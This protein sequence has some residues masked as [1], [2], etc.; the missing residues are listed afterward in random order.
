M[1]LTLVALIAATA[2][3]TALADS[4]VISWF[5]NTVVSNWFSSNAGSLGEP[6]NFAQN[7]CVTNPGPGGMLQLCAYDSNGTGKFQYQGQGWR[8][9]KRTSVWYKDESRPDQEGRE[10]WS[11]VAC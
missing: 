11:E 6:I 5:R 8:C 9:L 7:G 1:K 3:P 10:V 4:W 2:L